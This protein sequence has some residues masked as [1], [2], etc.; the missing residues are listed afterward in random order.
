MDLSYGAAAEAFRSEVRAFLAA[1]WQPGERRGGELKDYVRDFRRKGVA[2]GY[3]SRA[4]PRASGGSEASTA[5]ARSC[6]RNTVMPKS[7]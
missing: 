1:Q 4:I 2:A 6:V 5:R 3:L 7:F